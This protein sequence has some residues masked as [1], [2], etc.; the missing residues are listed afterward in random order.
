M[1]VSIELASTVVINHYRRLNRIFGSYFL[2]F[3][4]SGVTP[5]RLYRGSLTLITE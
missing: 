2:V 1:T 5:H 3:G 4:K